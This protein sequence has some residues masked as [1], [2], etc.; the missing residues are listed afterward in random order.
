MPRFSITVSGELNEFLEEESGDSGEFASK[1]KAVQHYIDR[2]REAEGLEREVEIL[3]NR[4]EEQRRQ[5]VERENVEEKV[6]VLA[7]RV[8]DQQAAADAPFFVRWVRWLR[9]RRQDASDNT[10]AESES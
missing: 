10:D 8:E 2:G 9:H 7:K 4:I 6:D 5:M 3:E 1:S